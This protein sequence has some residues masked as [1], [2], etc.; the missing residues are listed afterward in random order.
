[1]SCLLS[2]VDTK[3]VGAKTILIERGLEEL[4]NFDRLIKEQLATFT[5]DTSVDEKKNLVDQKQSAVVLKFELLLAGGKEIEALACVLDDDGGEI[6]CMQVA[7]QCLDIAV[8]IH[9]P[10][11]ST[12]TMV[13]LER[14]LDDMAREASGF[15]FDLAQYVKL[16]RLFVQT[17]LERGS[18]EGL[19]DFFESLVV[20]LDHSAAPS[21][22]N[23]DMI[24][25]DVL[26]ICV[27]TWNLATD[28][29]G[30]SNQV[31]AKLWMTLALKLAN[32]CRGDSDQVRAMRSSYA[33]FLEEEAA[34][35][36]EK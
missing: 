36:L 23:E 17:H 8:L 6:W 4:S 14:L 27:A 31:D 9:P 15:V 22:R 3:D 1:M 18:L 12:S 10:Q 13:L 34:G 32:H 30:L 16:S 24:R 33:D 5:A 19:F 26:W 20:L 29:W 2:R 25:S 21:P 7:F 11:S 28:L 35:Y